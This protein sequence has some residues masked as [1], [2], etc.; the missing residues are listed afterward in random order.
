MDDH[1]FAGLLR[2]LQMQS[3]GLL[4]Q[5]C[6]FRLV[7]VI[8]TGFADG[9]HSRMIEFVQQP[10][11]RGRRPRLYIQRMHAD[12]AVHVVILFSERFD[13]GGIVCADTNTQKVPHST[14]AR[15]IE[16]G[17]QRAVMGGEV[18]AI[19]VT[20]GIYKHKKTATYIV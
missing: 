1:R 12:R 7:V 17:I 8:Q 2:R 18:E 4:L 13:V 16:G 19:K 9:H 11:Q 10:V 15:R 20:M 5:L 14:L 6:R 3:E